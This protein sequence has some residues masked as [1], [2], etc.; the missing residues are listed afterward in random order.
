MEHC[1]D[2]GW[3][4]SNPARGVPELKGQKRPEREPW[5][6]E[7]LDAYRTVCPLESR[8]RLLMELC[9]GTGQRIGDVLNMRWS[10]IEDGG[11]LVRQSKTSKELWV[12]ILPELQAALNVASRHSVFIL[13]NER[14]ANRWSYRGASAAV[15]KVREQIGALDYHIHSWRYNAACE[16]LEAGCGDDLIAAVTGQSPAIVQ[17]YT[18]KVRQR[19]RAVQAQKMRTEQ[20]R[21]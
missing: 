2:L 10:N 21:S 17:H 18:K 7:L 6:R 8:Q 3:R 13:T 1:V 11:V 4:D 15:R 19:L 5:P 14:G 20:S 16:L 12:P 9:V